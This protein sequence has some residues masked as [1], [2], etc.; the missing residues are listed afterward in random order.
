[1]KFYENAVEIRT[2]SLR[3]SQR[4]ESTTKCRNRLKN[5]K[6]RSGINRKKTLI[7]ALFVLLL[8][9]SLAPTV[10]LA[11]SEVDFSDRAND[12]DFSAFD[13]Y[14]S[15]LDENQKRA[16]NFTSVK[17]L[18][19][20]LLLGKS[21]DFFENFFS[22]FGTAIGEYFFGFL[23]SFLAILLIAIFTSILS[24]A[25]SG[26]KQKSTEEVVRFVSFGAI[27]TIL[28]VVVG[29]ATSACVTL[30][31]NLKKVCSFLFPPLLTAL[32]ALGGHTTTAT[33]QPFMAILSGGIITLINSLI[34][35]IFMATTVLAIV[36]NLS[37]EVRLDKLAKSFKS[38][39]S[40]VLG[41]VFSLFI[42]FITAQGIAT[43]AFDG[44][45]FNASKFMVS[46]YVPILGG[47]LSDGYDLAFAGIVL[48]KNSIG[49][50]GTFILIATVAFPVCKMAVLS[51]A[52]KFTAAII[53]PLGEKRISNMLMMTSKNLSLLIAAAMGVA[54]MFLILIMLA[55]SSCNMG[56]L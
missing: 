14:I 2:E 17:E 52:M 16:L 1:M 38:F 51:L 19:E 6:R 45:T 4:N 22:V 54:F 31:S 28:L 26:F 35:P 5:A 48:L 43:S 8:F 21:E 56:A 36:G 44:V 27:A 9:F 39:G 55:I 49:L 25:V 12:V 33:L 32:S 11:A 42:S 47:Y 40:F 24:Q 20:K 3:R 34:V 41:G 29:A 50:V 23:P 18:V 53:E 37:K 46:S 10:C 7:L 13:D 15:A 30:L